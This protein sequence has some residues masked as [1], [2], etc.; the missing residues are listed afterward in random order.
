MFLFYFILLFFS[1]AVALSYNALNY[2]F[3]FK[4]MRRRDMEAIFLRRKTKGR[5]RIL[6]FVGLKR[7]GKHY[8][9]EKKQGQNKREGD[10]GKRR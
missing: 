2:F 7:G 10:L 8:K 9:G 5:S 1:E 6:S 4:W 3:F